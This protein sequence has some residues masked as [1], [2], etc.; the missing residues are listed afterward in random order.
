[1]D[2]TTLA[3]CVAQ[4][5]TSGWSEFDALHVDNKEI[6][7]DSFADGGVMVWEVRCGL[8]VLRITFDQHVLLIVPWCDVR[9]DRCRPQWHLLGKRRI[10]ELNSIAMRMISIEFL[11]VILQS[12]AIPAR[13]NH[14]R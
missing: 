12:A 5:H 14:R 11:R 1:M 10:S 13:S 4:A 8:S 6:K 7:E 3:S 9:L 2:T